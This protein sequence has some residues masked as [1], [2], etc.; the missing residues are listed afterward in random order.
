MKPLEEMTT[1]ELIDY[2]SGYLLMEIGRGKF[3]TG[4]GTI[5]LHTMNEAY[6]RGIKEGKKRAKN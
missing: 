5:L 1:S 4:V 2:W 6:Q 3:Q